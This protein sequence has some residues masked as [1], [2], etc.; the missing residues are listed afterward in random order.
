MDQQVQ[1]YI[2]T[3]RMNGGV[4]TIS[5]C[6]GVGLGIVTAVDKQLLSANIGPLRLSKHWI[7]SLLRQMKMVKRKG[8]CTENYKMDYYQKFKRLVLNTAFL[9]SLFTTETT[10]DCKIVSMIRKYHNHKLQTNPW[11]HEEEP[12]NN[13]NGR[14]DLEDSYC[15]TRR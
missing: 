15:W 3:L 8:S 10:Q 14:T 2:E 1:S 6:L 4:V 11:H 13:H 7:Y 12:H 5:I 9:Q